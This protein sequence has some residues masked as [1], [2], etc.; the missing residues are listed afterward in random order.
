MTTGKA[1]EIARSY[2]EAIANKDIET[3]LSISADDVVCSSPI[4]QTTGLDRFRAFHAGFARMIT[5]LTVLAVYGD[6]KQAVVVYDVETHPVPHAVT[7]ELIKVK[8][9]KLAS[10][11]VIYHATPFAAYMATVSPH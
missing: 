3:I 1:L 4:G 2:V 7:A 5:K 9:G 6:D 11:N 8:E 10:T